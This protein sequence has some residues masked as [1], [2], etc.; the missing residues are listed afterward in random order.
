MRTPAAAPSPAVLPCLSLT[1]TLHPAGHYI[2]Y[3]KA[4][5]SW[6]QCDDSTVTRVAAAKALSAGAYLL[7]YER[8]APRRIVAAGEAAVAVPA[9]AAAAAAEGAEVAAP[10][11]EAR[12]E[13]AAAA[14]VGAAE[15]ASSAA[16]A[17]TQA[18]G[19]LR[20]ETAP[21]SL[22]HL[23]A[24]GSGASLSAASSQELLLP[25]EVQ[26]ARQHRAAQAIEAG[27]PEALHAS[28]SESDLPAARLRSSGSVAAA[29]SGGGPGVP[30]TIA[31]EAAGGSPS[32]HAE[33]QQELEAA[34]AEARAEVEALLQQQASASPTSSSSSD[35]S[36][37]FRPTYNRF[38]LLGPEDSSGD[39]SSGSSSDA[40]ESNGEAEGSGSATG[41]PQAAAA[42]APAEEPA[43]E[44]APEVQ[45][46]RSAAAE[47]DVSLEQQPLQASRREQAAAASAAEPA[48]P[49]AGGAQR[50]PPPQQQPASGSSTAAG[51][52]APCTPAHRASDTSG[53]GGK[54]VL[55]LSVDLPG[56]QGMEHVDWRL[57]ASG[58]CGTSACQQ[59]LLRAEQWRL[60]LPLPV[61]VEG[62][63]GAAKWAPQ[64]LTVT[65][66]VL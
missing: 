10:A 46:G 66:P 31:E 15:A 24:E 51:G 58:S 2:A 39:R 40:D 18:S 21:A 35:G 45:A 44:A 4:N 6:F 32:T 9:K 59:L 27:T 64:K 1:P 53:A 5:G 56:V 41:E 11:A 17:A 38:N 29:A 26:E 63:G 57:Q 23:G 19:M 42:A 50:P 20:V 37:P 25:R 65:W 13:A 14:A 55:R 16:K 36:T 33:R 12:A 60:A 30:S 48:E 3:V 43:E 34:A 54:R 7:F 49:R 61:A 8:E 22:P 62:G 52:A 28:V 47:A